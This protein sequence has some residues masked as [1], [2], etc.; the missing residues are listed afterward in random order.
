MSSGLAGGREKRAGNV[1]GFASDLSITGHK[2]QMDKGKVSVESTLK[3][4]NWA[5][6]DHMK[7]V[8]TLCNLQFTFN[9]KLCL[10]KV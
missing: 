1:K 8:S 2:F 7:G 9:Y 3:G 4:G 10:S 5:N 6:M